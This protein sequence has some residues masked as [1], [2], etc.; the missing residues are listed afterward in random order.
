M[1]D[2]QQRL[3]AEILRLRTDAGLSR[4]VLAESLNVD[5]SH[6]ARIESGMARP[7]LELMTAIG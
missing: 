4:A 3:G 2:L 7:S 6:I 1:R 5:R